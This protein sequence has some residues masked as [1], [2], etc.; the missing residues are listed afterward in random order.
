MLVAVERSQCNSLREAVVA[1]ILVD[2]ALKLVVTFADE[3]ETDA[4]SGQSVELREGARNNQIAVFVHQRSNISGV[5]RDEAG[6]SLV[7]Q[8]HRVRRDV[9]HDAS[10]LLGRQS[11]A[12]RV[13]GRSQQQ[14][15]GMHAVGVLNHLV[16]IIGEGVVFL[17]QG[18]HLKRTATLRGNAVV[19]PPRELRDKNLLVVTQHQEIVDGIFQHVFAAIG[20]Q[21]LVFGHAIDFA[22]AYGDDA[23]LSLVIDS[24]VKT[25]CFRIKILNGLHH[26]LAGLKIKFVSVEIIHFLFLLY[27]YFNSSISSTPYR[28]QSI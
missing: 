15:A 4:Q 8:H 6:I 20:Q 22:E 3:S 10:N 9:L 13:V 24:G 25:Q 11:V 7:N 1:Q 12:C 14:H 19:I 5:G 16:D 28:W 21:H 27:R 18:V 17:V 23:L 2:I 26:F